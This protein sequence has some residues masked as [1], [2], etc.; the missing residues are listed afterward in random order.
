MGLPDLLQWGELYG[1]TGTITVRKKIVE[2][3]IY[4]E[5][6]RIIY[7]SSSREGERLG[8]YLHRGAHIDLDKI[9]TALLQAQNL[10]IPFTQRLLKMN[11]FTPAGLRSVIE[12]HALEILID[13]ARWTEGTFEFVQGELPGDVLAGP[14][15]LNASELGHQ[16]LKVLE[17]SR[18]GL[19]KNI[20]YFFIIK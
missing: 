3:K 9:K 18:T 19:R 8:E 14:I 1:K 16:M 4:M 2:K 15:K 5:G 11:Y 12:K 13:A 17:D 7:V 20:S 6:G 10:K